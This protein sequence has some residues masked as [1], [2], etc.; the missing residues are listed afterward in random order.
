MSAPIYS[1]PVAGTA[2]NQTAARGAHEAAIQTVVNAL[3]DGRV[4]GDAAEAAARAAAI[5]AQDAAQIARARM[6]ARRDG[7]PGDAP[8]LFSRN[9]GEIVAGPDG[10]VVRFTG[11]GRLQAGAL[12]PIDPDGTAEAR[13]WW[14]RI[15]DSLDPA[16]DAVQA[17]IDWFNAAGTRISGTAVFTDTAATVAAGQRRFRRLIRAGAGAWTTPPAAAGLGRPPVRGGGGRDT[18]AIWGGRR[19]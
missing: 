14:R 2:P 12:T 11:P 10:D 6:E 1:L 16:L 18:R 5:E 19:G 7:R 15:A 9:A 8:H 17:G 3:H 4:A 13:W